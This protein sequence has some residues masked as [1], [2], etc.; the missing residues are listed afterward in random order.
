MHRKEKKEKRKEKIEK[1]KEKRE[2][3]KP[4]KGQCFRTQRLHKHD[5]EKREEK[6]TNEEAGIQRQ[7]VR[8]KEGGRSGG[9]A[10]KTRTPHLGCGEKI[11]NFMKNLK[12]AKNIEKIE[13]TR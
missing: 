7:R 5:A 4:T 8:R 11:G 2:K 9:G 3:R 1:R 12:N 6:R 13:K 10:R